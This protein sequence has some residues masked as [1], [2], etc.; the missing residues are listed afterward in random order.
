MSYSIKKEESKEQYN[1]I[2]RINSSSSSNNTKSITKVEEINKDRR[3]WK[4]KYKELEFYNKY[5]NNYYSNI[6][7]YITLSNINIILYNF[8]I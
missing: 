2:S 7:I 4:S 1:N 5:F 8:K 3:A 6:K